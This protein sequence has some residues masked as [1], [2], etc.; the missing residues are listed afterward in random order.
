MVFAA[1]ASTRCR[2]VL[3]AGDESLRGAESDLCVR[4]I[5]KRLGRRAA[6]TAERNR[7]ARQFVSRAI[8]V[9]Y[10]NIIAFDEIRSV[11]ADFD[12]GHDSSVVPA[13]TGRKQHK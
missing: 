4:A 2:L 6:A 11:L 5:T 3:A 12:G 7:F 9:Q 13:A 10:L 1:A 8:P